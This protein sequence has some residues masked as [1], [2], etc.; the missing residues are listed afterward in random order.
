MKLC[1]VKQ[2]DRSSEPIR[3]KWG[4]LSLCSSGAALA[5]GCLFFRLGGEYVHH[6]GYLGTASSMSPESTRGALLILL[7]YQQDTDG[8]RPF[9]KKIIHS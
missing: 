4:R 5:L 6:L 2:I 8:E 3:K 9:T 1:L 7:E